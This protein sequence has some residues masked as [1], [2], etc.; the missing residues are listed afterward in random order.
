MQSKNTLFV[1]LGDSSA[2]FTK[3]LIKYLE[4][5]YDHPPYIIYVE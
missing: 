5:E 2:S 3:K 1:V 4:L